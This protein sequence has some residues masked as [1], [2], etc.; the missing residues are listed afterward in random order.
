MMFVA[1]G[2][3]LLIAFIVAL[4]APSSSGFQLDDFNTSFTLFFGVGSL[5]AMAVSGRMLGRMRDALWWAPVWM[6][7]SMTLY[8]VGVLFIGG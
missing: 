5:I 6:A 4:F 7:A 3:P 2:L 1:V 8:H